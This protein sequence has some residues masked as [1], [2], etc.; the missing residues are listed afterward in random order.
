[1]EAVYSVNLSNVCLRD[2]EMF[3]VL[4]IHGGSDLI[5]MMQTFLINNQAIAD[6]AP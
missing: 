1:M 4:E 2:S 5:Q 3:S 6:R